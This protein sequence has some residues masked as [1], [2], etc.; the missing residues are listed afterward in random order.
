MSA[1]L[2]RIK[3][4]VAWLRRTPLHP[5]WLLARTT[6]AAEWVVQ[7]ASGRVLD[8]GCADRWV[9]RAL[10][11]Q[12]SYLA[13]DYP[14]TGAAIYHARPHVYATASALPLANDCIDTAL[15][16]EVTEHLA[17]PDLALA[18]V[19]RVLRP[20]GRLLLSM[21]FLYPIHDAPH[22]Y[23]RFTEHGLRR[24]VEAAGL[25]IESLERTLTSAETSA[26]LSCLMLSGSFVEAMRQRHPAVVLL[27]LL[28]L[29]IPLINMGGWIAGRLLPDWSACTLGYRLHARR[30]VDAGMVAGADAAQRT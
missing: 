24:R 22:D 7:N 14:D 13:L 15:L 11:P 23:Q 29:A 16:L 5:Q 4:R 17:D 30:P 18:E 10:S 20:G 28:A 19:A 26:V 1:L 21:P 3:K 9:E 27:P 8:V 6:A 25:K 12:C 2:G